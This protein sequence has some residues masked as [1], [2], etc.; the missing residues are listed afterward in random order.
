[1]PN[2]K[3]SPLAA[4]FLALTMQAASANSDDAARG[5]TVSWTAAAPSAAV[6]PGAPVTLTVQGK[7][8][9]GWH[10]YG[11]KQLPNGPTPLKLGVDANPA[12]VSDGAAGGSATTK[13][14]DRGFD[15]DVEYYSSAFA[16]TMPVRIAAGAAAGVQTVPLSVRF[17]TCNDRICQPPKT[18]HLSASVNVQAGG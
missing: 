14:H 11:L 9:E 18:V 13:V 8:L 2:T 17:Q 7:V 1:M 15:L 12:A 16:L 4:A 3:F 5:E 10:V 6:K